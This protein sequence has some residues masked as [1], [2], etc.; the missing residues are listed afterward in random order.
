M[1]S[2]RK[3]PSLVAKFYVPRLLDSVLSLL[4]SSLTREPPGLSAVELLL[5]VKLLFK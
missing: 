4:T 3:T 2:L 5:V 1:H